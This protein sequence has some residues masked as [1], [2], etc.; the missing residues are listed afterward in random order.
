M[1]SQFRESFAT[2]LL[3][4]AWSLALFSSCTNG[5]DSKAT[6][7]PPKANPPA[8]V[9]NMPQAADSAESQLTKDA[10]A[11]PVA[12][13]STVIPSQKEGDPKAAASI[14]SSSARFTGGIDA[15]RRSQLAFRQMGFIAE[16][17]AKPG[18]I[19]KKGDVLAVLD[20]RDYRIRLELAKARWEQARVQA[21]S[22]QKDYK[23][24]IELQ[25]E[26]A[27]TSATL[28]RVKAG[29]D[30]ARQAMRLAELDLEAATL[31]NNDAKLT[32][33]YDCIVATQFKHESENV[34]SGAPVFEIYDTAEPEVNLAVPE[35]LFG[36]ITLGTMLMVTV[37]SANF[38]S[39]AKVVRLVPVISER[40]RT[41]R[42]TAKLEVF[43]SR[44]VP[45]SYAEA[46]LQ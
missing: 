24:E 39:K 37:P 32:A 20:D 8:Q 17:T 42:I 30:S 35:R 11:Q 7:P 31:A 21:D 41:F 1:V 29:Y 2:G 22:A 44:I 34:Q 4:G 9:A 33:P 38:S 5:Q 16:I 19:A 3:I 15:P 13:A 36:Q 12:D 25:K 46:T 28:D 18:T 10:D 23:R 45:G 40:T 6:L 26:N 43:D 27:S 14:N